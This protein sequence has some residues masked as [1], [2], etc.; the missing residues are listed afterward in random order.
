[1]VQIGTRV[2]P[3]RMR[4][5]LRALRYGE[6]PHA[7]L[8]PESTGFVPALPWKKAWTQASVS[9]GH[10]LRFSLWQH[11]AGLAAVVRGGRW[12]PLRLIEAVE[13]DGLRYSLPRQDGERVFSPQ[14][15]A[16]VR[17]MM[18][19]GAEVGTGEPVAG[20]AVL[21]ELEVGTKTGTAEK[22]ASEMCLHAE[23][24]HNETHL[25]AKSSCS[26]SC[27][28]SLLHL[29]D[30][31]LRSTAGHR[32]RG[33]GAG[34]RRRAAGR[35]VWLARRRSVRH[36]DPARGLGRDRVGCFRGR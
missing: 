4:G 27:R 17:E 30:L 36:R 24:G 18:R 5:F 2:D 11:A 12:L 22:V 10:E 9:F 21:P 13:Q 16:T 15:C 31:R 29:F 14:T 20:P 28:A 3:E 34:R 32:S 1:M 26:K 6:L 23:L 8:G 19:L 7:G 25:R 33:V 35:E